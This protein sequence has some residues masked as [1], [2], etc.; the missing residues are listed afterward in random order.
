MPRLLEPLVSI[1]TKKIEQA[2][3]HAKDKFFDTAATMMSFLD[4]DH[5]NIFRLHDSA[6]STSSIL[7]DAADYPEPLF[8]I[9]IN[10]ATELVDLYGP[11]LYSRN[12]NRIVRVRD[13][14]QFDLASLMGFPEIIDSFFVLQ[15]DMKQR[16]ALQ[17][18]RAAIM[19]QVLNYTPGELDL[20][21][22]SRLAVVEGLV[23]GRGI[24]W[25]EIYQP[26]G[27]TSRMPGS[28][29]ENVE[30]LLVDP[31]VRRVMHAKW[32]ARRHITPWWELAERFPGVD[33]EKL[34]GVAQG[35]SHETQATTSYEEYGDY[36]RSKGM[37]N[38]LV[39]WY[40]IWSKMGAGG[41]LSGAEP[42]YL[43]AFKEAGR[44]CYLCIAPGYPQLL[45]VPDQMLTGDPASVT[46][47]LQWPTMLWADNDWPFTCLDFKHNPDCSWPIS[48]LA[49][50]QGEMEWIDWCASFLASHVR[51]SCRQ[52][53]AALAELDEEIKQQL[54]SG[55]DMSIIEFKGSTFKSINDAIQFLSPPSLNRD[56]LEVLNVFTLWFEQRTGLSELMYAAS[57]HQYRSAQEAQVK[58]EQMRIRPDDMAETMEAFMG[59]VARKEAILWRTTMTKAD[60]APL[61]GEQFATMFEQFILG[62]NIEEVTRELDYTIEA[63]SAR[64]PNLDRDVENMNE[65]MQVVFPVLYQTAMQ[66]GDVTVVNQM[67]A[68]WARSRQLDPEKYVIR[69][70][71]PPPQVAP[72][73]GQQQGGKEPPPEQ[74]Q[75]A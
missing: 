63:G 28:F 53:I 49:P 17:E 29:F 32:A 21:Y 20:R 44:F 38:D 35:E 48:T 43:E 61:F 31:D 39:T 11:H 5:A 45:N 68:D 47:L 67:L 4:G 18:I 14:P 54:R 6:N 57:P 22:H 25:S 50:A 10:K 52:F 12:P 41:L 34:R 66:T 51:M 58:A 55:S 70:T 26:P 74:Q 27:A 62:S 75:A 71:P 59:K 19:Q 56:V 33:A 69:A 16:R 1:W 13:I 60:I 30:N 46:P 42:A 24:L 37:T 2:R 7:K 64:K 9:K 72:E 3:R 40:E 65:V 15:E 23:K 8:N 36:N 73:G